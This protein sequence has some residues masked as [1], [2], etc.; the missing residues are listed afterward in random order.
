[1][2]MES[3][4]AMI[5]AALAKF[6]SDFSA[7]GRIMNYCK[8]YSTAIGSFSLRHIYYEANDSCVLVNVIV[9]GISVL[10]PP[11]VATCNHN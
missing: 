4:C 9:L 2:D 3:D 5:V 10:R 8:E 7:Q 11:R 1:M 6:G